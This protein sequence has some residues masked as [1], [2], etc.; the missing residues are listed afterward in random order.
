MIFILD[1][2]N[3]IERLAVYIMAYRGLKV[4]A[5]Q[6][7]R[8]WG[9]HYNT[10]PKGKQIEGEFNDDVML[11]IKASELNNKTPF[12]HLTTN[13]LKLRIYKATTKWITTK[14][15]SRLIWKIQKNLRN[16]SR[17]EYFALWGVVLID[18]YA[19]ISLPANLK[20]PP[21]IFEGC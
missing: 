7:L 11:N 12:A 14:K 5:L 2:L 16:L 17:L 21:D 1:K 9:T 3:E 10:V 4:G 6:Q 20:E 19:T 18:G 13:A 8:I 15:S